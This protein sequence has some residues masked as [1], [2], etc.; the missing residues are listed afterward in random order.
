MTEKSITVTRKTP[1]G[2]L[3]LI[4]IISQNGVTKLSKVLVQMGQNGV[5]ASTQA[6]AH[7][8]CINLA[9]QSGANPLSVVEELS[10]IRCN[11]Q[12]EERLSCSHSISKAIKK[13]LKEIGQYEAKPVA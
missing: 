6:E 8:R 7:A 12:D 9:L 11:T 2:D 1:C 10:G 13:V 3:T 5:C 4:A